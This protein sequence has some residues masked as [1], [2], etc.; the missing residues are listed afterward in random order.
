MQHVPQAQFN[1]GCMALQLYDDPVEAYF[2]W[3]IVGIKHP[4]AAESLRKLIELMPPET[5][6]EAER[7]YA[8]AFSSDYG[9]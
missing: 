4:K 3:R 8:A 6:R 2:W 9:P 7:R 1:I 5:L